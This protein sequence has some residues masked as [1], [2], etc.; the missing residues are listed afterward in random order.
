MR[1]EV[2][3]PVRVITDDGTVAALAPRPRSL[4]AALLAS[5]G[6]LV[7][8]ERL[9]AEL[10]P[11]DAPPTAAAALQVHAPALRKAVG[12]RLP[13]PAGAY[14]IRADDHDAE[15]FETTGDLGLWRGPAYEGPDR[16]PIV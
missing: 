7:S 15:E 3:G 9:I 10:W 4:L 8:A 16:G 6:Q 5:G 2:L 11:V 12:D 13:S 14:A 1:F